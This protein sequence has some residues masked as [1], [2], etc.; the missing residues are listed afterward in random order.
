M[1]VVQISKIQLRRGRI[2]QTGLPQ[3]ASGEL[4]WAIDTQ[5]LFVGNGSVAEG[6]PYVGRTKILTEHDSILDLIAQYQYK[7]DNDIVGT[8]SRT[9]Q[10]RLDDG[11]VN[12][13]SFGITNNDPTLDQ[14]VQIQ[15]AVNSLYQSTNFKDHVTLEFD[16]G[17]YKIT[18][19][20]V[21]PTNT[22]IA[23]SGKDKTIFNFNGDG[24]TTEIFKFIN[25][26]STADSLTTYINQPKNIYLNGFTVQSNANN[27]LVINCNNV[28]DS[29]F[30]NIKLVGS[31]AINDGIIANSKAIELDANSSVVTCQRN[32]FSNL[33]IEGFT[34]GIY[35]SANILNNTIEN[36]NFRTLYRGVSFGETSGPAT[37][38]I[39]NN[40]ISNQFE[41]ISRE[42]IIVDKGYG[43]ISRGNKFINVGNDDGGL[44]N[45]R[46][47]QI[48]F[49]APG[50]SSVQ[51]V[52]DRIALSNIAGSPTVTRYLPEVLGTSYR[53]ENRAQTTNL[54]ANEGTALRLPVNT[55]NSFRID[56][57]FQS[58]QF[59][60]M[61]KGTLHV[62]VDRENENFQLVDEYEYTGETGGDDKLVFTAEPRFSEDGQNHIEITYVNDN[63]E[64]G[65]GITDNNTFTYTITTLS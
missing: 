46:S 6:A 1:A 53:Q 58:T 59:I 24:S 11:S 38:P 36:S 50:N 55:S 34:Y 25:D 32:T 28:R 4:A 15:T 16:P 9:L 45:N 62:A 31:W 18:G 35:S 52:F 13:A 3:L 12:A 61:R 60:Q 54:E 10:Q 33:S 43:N 27:I 14:T 21:L 37:G 17:I 5:E 51:D 20:I 63:V 30:S 56:Y 57:I 44:S 19:T 8:A 7:S 48:K 29:A 39:N 26:D 23:G 47:A 64:P 65:L 41:L 49:T 42:G 2:N 40:I 22:S